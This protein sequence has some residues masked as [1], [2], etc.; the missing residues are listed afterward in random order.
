MFLRIG[1]FAMLAAL[2]PSLTRAQ[3]RITTVAGSTRTFPSSANGGPAIDAPLL[4]VTGV[5]VD[6][7]GNIYVA[8]A[9][10]N[11]VARIAPDGT[12]TVIAG[13]LG[14]GFLGD[15]GPAVSAQLLSPGGLALDTS[16][17]LYITVIGR[18]RKVTPQGP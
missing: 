18:V 7:A 6:T 1:L 10:D 17:N 14:A 5:A 2:A 16:G 13:D 15:G 8:D 11:M 9:A 3:G 4:S 12:F